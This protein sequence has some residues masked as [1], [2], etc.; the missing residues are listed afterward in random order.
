MSEV[1]VGIVE[2]V[3]ATS[4]SFIYNQSFKCTFSSSHKLEQSYDVS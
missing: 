4:I 2:L 1:I 3:V